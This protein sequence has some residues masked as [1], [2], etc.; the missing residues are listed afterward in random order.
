MYSSRRFSQSSTSMSEESDPDPS[1]LLSSPELFFSVFWSSFSS[2]SLPLSIS[3][4]PSP[5]SLYTE[6]VMRDLLILL[7][8]CKKSDS[9]NSTLLLRH[10]PELKNVSLPHLHLF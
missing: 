1:S 6:G 4:S 2:F 7:I 3:L 9:L 5:S 8:L 10:P